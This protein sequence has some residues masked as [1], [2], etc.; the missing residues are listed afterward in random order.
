MVAEDFGRSAGTS[1]TS[2]QNDVIGAGIQ[3]ELNIPLDVIG[4]EFETY[5]NS[6]GDFPNMAGEALEILDR[7]QIL[8]RGW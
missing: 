5:R 7:A 6:A 8:E 1:A 2:V 3:R 4:A